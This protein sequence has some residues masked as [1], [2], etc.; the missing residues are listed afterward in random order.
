[1]PN[2]PPLH[3]RILLQEDDSYSVRSYTHQYNQWSRYHSIRRAFYRKLKKLPPHKRIKVLDIGCGTGWV[4]RRLE[5]EFA[6]RYKLKFFAIDKSE[7]SAAFAVETKKYYNKYVT[8][9]A[10]DA[11]G[12]AFNNEEFDIIICSELIEHIAE[13]AEVVSELYRILKKGGLVIITTPNKGSGL[14]A[15]FLRLLKKKRRNRASSFSSFDD[16][17]ENV[18]ISVKSKRE[19][20]RIFIKN[21]LKITSVKGTS[22]LLYGS[23][24]LDRYRV[25]F[26][27]TII[28]EA[29]LE[30]LPFYHLWAETLFFELKK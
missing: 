21:D 11:K 29:I 20:A 22:G 1:M 4:S 28:L 23:P 2:N 18:H 6:A 13:P 30:K 27:I 17:T 10:M 12:L 14:L 5:K 15:K 26:A 9:L 24:Y 8:F 16:G 3:I 25:F 7:A 19:W